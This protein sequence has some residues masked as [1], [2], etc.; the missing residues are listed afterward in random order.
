MVIDVLPIVNDDALTNQ[1]EA[2]IPSFP[3][4]TDLVNTNIRITDFTV[5]TS[6]LSTYDINYK[7]Q[8]FPKPGGKVTTEKTFTF[9]F[10][11]D[12]FYNVYRGFHTWKNLL[13]NDYTGIALTDFS[14]GVSANRVPISIF[15][16][17]TNNVP[18]TKG[19][20]FFG[21]FPSSVAGFTYSYDDDKPLT[22]SITMKYINYIFS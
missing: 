5:P 4:V 15:P 7:S 2:V 19:W 11:V 16:I 10:R 12:K 18:L 14:A 20:Q 22:C 21:C 1:W 17:D 6:V 3:G 8:K 9:T 13:M